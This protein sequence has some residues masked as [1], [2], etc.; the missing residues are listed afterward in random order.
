MS[1]DLWLRDVQQYRDQQLGVCYTDHVRD[2]LRVSTWNLYDAGPDVRT[3]SLEVTHAHV[4][5]RTDLR[6]IRDN[7]DRLLRLLD[8]MQILWLV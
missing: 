2:R 1:H 5:P 8:R 7:R 4:D 3:D 6:D